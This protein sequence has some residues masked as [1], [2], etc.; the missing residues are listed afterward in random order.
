MR[1][2]LAASRTQPQWR[3]SMY[4]ASNDC[5]EI[6]QVNGTIMLRN[7]TK[8]RRVVRYTPEEWRAF[9]QGLQAGLRELE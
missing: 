3:R 7:S 5:V 8:P 4:C 1:L 9:T 6:A 2:K